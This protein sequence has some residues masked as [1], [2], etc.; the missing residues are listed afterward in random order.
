MTLTFEGIV[1]FVTD[2]QASARLYE[3][4]L[5]L[6]RDWADDNH[7]QFRL[8]TKDNPQGAW[9]LLHPTTGQSSAQHLGSF[10]VEDVDA[11]VAGLRDAGF[12]VTQEPADMPWGVREASVT[13]PDGNG[14]TLTCR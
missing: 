10:S 3:E 5:G 8:P 4:T 2:V 13:D 7:V 9:L 14:L 1:V 11:V 6:V 12:S